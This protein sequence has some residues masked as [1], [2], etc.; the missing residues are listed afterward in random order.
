MQVTA[1]YVEQTCNANAIPRGYAYTLVVVSL[2]KRWVNQ[3]IPDEYRLKFLE[4][5]DRM[6]GGPYQWLTADMIAAVSPMCDR[7]YEIYSEASK[8]DR[9]KPGKPGMFDAL[10]KFFPA[11][12]VLNPSLITALEMGPRLQGHFRSVAEDALQS[13]YF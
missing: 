11:F 1:E 7:G 5:F 2:I 10:A 9:G 12:A 4:W 6:K 13:R 3:D 8:L